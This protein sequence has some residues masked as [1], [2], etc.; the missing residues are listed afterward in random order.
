[1]D[2]EEFN[3][4]KKMFSNYRKIK[5]ER[6]KAQSLESLKYRVSSRIKTTMIGAI[7]SIEN[8]FGYLWGH[9]NENLNESQS[10]LKFIFEELRKEI[11][12]K[13]NNQLRGLDSDLLNYE[14]NKKEIK[15]VLPIRRGQKDE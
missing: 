11:L 4:N 6:S 3:K 13:G 8:H 7:S 9:G 10:R 12:D 5:E 1:M 2:S 14:V 15:I